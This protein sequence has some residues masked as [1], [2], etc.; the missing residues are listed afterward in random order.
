MQVDTLLIRNIAHAEYKCGRNI[1]KNT[2]SKWI[3]T[4]YSRVLLLSLNPEFY[5][6]SFSLHVLFN[7]DTQSNP[8]RA[9]KWAREQEDRR[10]RRTKET[11]PDVLQR[12]QNKGANGWENGGRGIVPGALLKLLVK[13]K[14][15]ATPEKYPWTRKNGSWDPWRERS[16]INEFNTER[17]TYISCA[18]PTLSN[19]SYSLCSSSTKCSHYR[20]LLQISSHVWWLLVCQIPSVLLF[21][22]Q[23]QPQH[24]NAVACSSGRLNLGS[25]TP[26]WCSTVCGRAAGWM[27][28]GSLFKPCAPL[29]SQPTRNTAILV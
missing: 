20:Q 21:C 15:L 23:L 28:G 19:W 5:S 27:W 26:P 9:L 12:Q 2:W 3:N 25:S 14:L 22:T 11:E 7:M 1:E 18:F 4:R 8:I 17:V 6:Q 29:C 10:R 24:L 13:D 16:N